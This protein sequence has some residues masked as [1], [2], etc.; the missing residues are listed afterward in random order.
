VEQDEDREFAE[1]AQAWPVEEDN[2][3]L[4]QLADVRLIS[5][6][7]IGVGP[8]LDWNGRSTDRYLSSLQGPAGIEKMALTLRREMA[9]FITQQIILLTA[10]G[11]KWTS[12]A[13]GETEADKQVKEFLDSVMIDMSTSWWR[14][15]QF[16]LS[17]T[18]FGYADVEIVWKRRMGMT[19]NPAMPDSQFDDQ[20]IGVRKLAPRRQETIDH[21]GQDE[22]GGY[23]TMVQLHP[24]TGEEIAIPI[25][26]LLHFIGG[27]DRGS[28]EGL[29]WLEP[30]YK[31]VHMLDS[32]EILEGVG[33]QR[34]F[35]GLPVA[36]YTRG[37]D[38]QLKN[39]MEALCRGLVMNTNQYVTIP[40]ESVEF[41]LVT[42]ANVNAGALKNKIDGLRWDILTT[43]LAAFL[44]LGS[45]ATG[46]YS[47]GESLKDVFASS[48]DAALDMVGDVLNRHLVPRLLAAN[49][50]SFV[51]I[52]AQPKY[53]HSSVKE[54]P[55]AVLQYLEA[56][57]TW[58]G[59]ARV[60]DVIWLRSE[61]GMPMVTQETLQTERAEAEAKAKAEEAE[62]VRQAQA[63]VPQTS[64]APDSEEDTEA[65][66]EASVRDLV[67]NVKRR[68]VDGIAY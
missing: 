16:A 24:R 13:G 59:T 29:G 49:P 48:V 58:N 8:M 26:K 35:V 68:A 61:I 37:V 34:S 43:G 20:M 51:G 10:K 5:E 39:K 45:T 28:W 12:E 33:W 42:V 47:L 27:D 17:A 14:V 52:S 62:A 4:V 36:H 15:V 22:H 11:S 25:E 46:T 60:E 9:V 40:K 67:A 31:L 63:L 57:S 3:D 7:E 64:T 66:E 54:L 65:E 1:L 38:T 41:E 21:W 55:M 44:R 6:K 2:R 23:Q 32:Y 50:A 53:V 18:A 56:I 19:A 30:A